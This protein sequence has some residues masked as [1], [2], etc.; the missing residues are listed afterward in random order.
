MTSLISNGIALKVKHTINIKVIPQTINIF[1][2][3]AWADS[4]VNFPYHA[5]APFAVIQFN[6]NSVTLDR[7]FLGLT[8]TK[9]GLMCL[10]Q[11]HN[12]VTPVR[13][14]PVALQ[15]RVKHSTTE[16]LRS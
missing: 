16:P 7:V 3:Q 1:K 9:L 4:H 8:S 13:L 2:I 12:T 6:N 11:G 5:R 10:A 15:T 14:E